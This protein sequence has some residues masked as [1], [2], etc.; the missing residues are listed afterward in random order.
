M[1]TCWHDS[2]GGDAGIVTDAVSERKTGVKDAE[3]ITARIVQDE[4]VWLR[5][6][7]ESR[8]SA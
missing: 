1:R 6:A 7:G 8:V 5:L 2:G 4:R 3:A